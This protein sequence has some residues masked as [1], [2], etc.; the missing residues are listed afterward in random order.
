M[1]TTPQIVTSAA[2]IERLIA[3]TQRR[4]T[5][6]RSPEMQHFLRKQEIKLRK[7]LDERIAQP[8]TPRV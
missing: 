5:R 2:T 3:G 1:N 7:L 4:L 8:P 6:A